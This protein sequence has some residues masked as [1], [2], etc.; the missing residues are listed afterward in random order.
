[1][2]AHHADSFHVAIC[3]GEEAL[4]SKSHLSLLVAH[5]VLGLGLELSPEGLGP[6]QA[7]AC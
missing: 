1:M 3:E 7:S 2:T 5:V 6:G 4:A